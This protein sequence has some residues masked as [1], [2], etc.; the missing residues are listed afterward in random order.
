MFSAWA[1]NQDATKEAELEASFTA[2][3]EKIDKFLEKS[4]GRLLCGD[5]WAIADCVFVPRLYHMV[6]VSRHFKKYTKFEDLPHILKYMDDTFT[7]DVFKV[8]D[9]PPE[10]I[11]QG[12]AKYFK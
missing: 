9:Y 7:T 3:L 5:G 4:P 1:K 6:T 8:T 11:L 10:Y 12:W 2:A